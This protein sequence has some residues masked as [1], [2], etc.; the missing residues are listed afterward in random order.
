MLTK[1][2]AILFIVVLFVIIFF[3]P[4]INAGLYGYNDAM[5]LKYRLTEEGIVA[6]SLIEVI[7]AFINVC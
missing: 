6:T 1:K 5:D 7:V 3:I 4:V 2:E